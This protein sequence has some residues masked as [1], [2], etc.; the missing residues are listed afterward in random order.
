MARRFR[1]GGTI[2]S[3]I[4]NQPS[5]LPRTAGL[6][7]SWE[8][9]NWLTKAHHSGMRH[10]LGGDSMTK[11]LQK[12]WIPLSSFPKRDNKYWALTRDVIFTVKSAYWLGILGKERE[13]G[14][15]AT[16]AF[17]D[18]WARIWVLDI[19]SKIKHLL[20]RFC[21]GCVGVLERLHYRYILDSSLYPR[22]LSA[23]KTVI[24]AIMD[25]LVSHAA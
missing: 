3:R 23:P 14:T 15:L 22:C 11:W 20:W 13:D 24:H 1:C 17:D 4:G 18:C 8:F 2:G 5:P 7:L 16:G 21:Q 9:A 19:P 10:R 25:C 12:S 6:W